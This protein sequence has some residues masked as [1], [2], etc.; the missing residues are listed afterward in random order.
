M[1]R[2]V[3]QPPKASLIASDLGAA[4]N[5]SGWEYCGPFQ[6]MR[7]GSTLETGKRRLR[8]LE[9]PHVHHWDSMMVFEETTRGLF[10][11]DLFLQPGE[12]RPVIHENLG[13]EMCEVYRTVGIFGAREPVLQTVDRLEKLKCKWIHPMH[14]GSLTDEIAPRFIDA[15]RMER[16]W[17]DGRVFG[18][19]LPI[20]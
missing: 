12:Q 6:G 5:L 2:L 9:T 4:L 10:R 11:A 15:L 7:D 19:N 16:F 13:K 1:K 14:G 20:G 3:E 17:Y 18:R 8:F